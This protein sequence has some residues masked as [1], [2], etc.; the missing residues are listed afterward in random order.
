MPSPGVLQ[1]VRLP[2]GPD[3][4]VDTYAYCGS[5]VPDEYDP[6]IAKLIVWGSDRATCLAR[7]RS[8]LQECQF[9]GTATNLSLVQRLLDQ[10]DFQ[11]GKYSTDMLPEAAEN[12]GEE[13]ARRYR[14]LAAAA[15]I[16]YLRRTQFFR[17]T[18]PERLTS[19]WH[20]SSRR[21][22]E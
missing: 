11:Q 6:L 22:P 16:A 15:A 13:T 3:V 2:G 9:S 7:L 21:L 20:R 1:K 14:D 4:R 18:T 19:G 12:A 10:P 5:T 8:A 17:P